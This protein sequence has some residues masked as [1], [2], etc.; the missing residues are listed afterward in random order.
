[1]TLKSFLSSVNSVLDLRGVHIVPIHI[2]SLP[3]SVRIHSIW[4]PPFL[5]S[6]WIAMFFGLPLTATSLPLTRDLLFLKI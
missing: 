3:L 2:H 6:N 5:S 4:S 1:M